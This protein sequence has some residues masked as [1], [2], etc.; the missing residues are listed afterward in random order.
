MDSIAMI[1]LQKAALCLLLVALLRSIEHT[2][3]RTV[4][5]QR[6]LCSCGRENGGVSLLLLPALLCCSSARDVHMQTD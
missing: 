5:A 3:T 4:Q 6:G 1:L 2:V